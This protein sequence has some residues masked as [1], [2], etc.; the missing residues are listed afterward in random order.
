MVR[1]R[2]RLAPYR[3]LALPVVE[4]GGHS[5]P[6]R[7]DQSDPPGSPRCS[8]DGNGRSDTCRTMSWVMGSSGVTGPSIRGYVAIGE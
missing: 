8:L 2:D 7:P 1:H 3:P 5:S 4:E 6:P